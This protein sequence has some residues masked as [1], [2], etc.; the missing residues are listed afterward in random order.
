[1]KIK[2]F[3]VIGVLLITGITFGAFKAGAAEGQGKN[4]GEVLLKFKDMVGIAGVFVGTTVCTQPTRLAFERYA[5]A[6]L[7]YG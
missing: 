6:G 5:D 7:P 4:R 3:L 2:I 1:M